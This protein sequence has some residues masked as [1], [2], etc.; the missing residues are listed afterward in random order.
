LMDYGFHAPTLAFP[1]PG[2]LMVEPTESES[3]AELD[4]FIEAMTQI[5]AEIQEVID[6]KVSAEESVLR[7][8]PH[9]AEVVTA[10]DCLDPDATTAA[11][12]GTLKVGWSAPL[13]GP[14][15]AAAGAVI[16]AIG[17]LTKDDLQFLWLPLSHVFGKMLVATGLQIGFPTAVDGRVEKIVDNMAVIKPTFMAGPPRIFEKAHGRVELMFAG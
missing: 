16:D 7:N 17:T 5:H 3:L 13:S 6:G 8:A 11:I 10:D 1:V 2:T 4:R 12:T 15:A 9:T 14:L